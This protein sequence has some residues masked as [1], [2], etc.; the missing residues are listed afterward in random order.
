MR[1]KLNR[2]TGGNATRKCIWAQRASARE[3]RPQMLV[4]P[5]LQH[6]YLRIKISYSRFCCNLRLK[7][8]ELRT[9]N[10]DK[11][12]N[13]VL[14]SEFR[15]QGGCVCISKIDPT[16]SLLFS[17]FLNYESFYHKSAS[18][19]FVWTVTVVPQLVIDAR[20]MWLVKIFPWNISFCISR[21]ISVILGWEN[22]KER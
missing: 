7:P 16:Y 8:S 9:Q 19:I 3:P 12:P 15:T 21:Y 10:S 4:H 1:P 13:W 17:V 11:N 22:H 14:S 20:W 5:N 2:I 18:V 6:K